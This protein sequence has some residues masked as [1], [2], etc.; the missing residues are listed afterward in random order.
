MKILISYDGSESS[1]AALQDLRLAGLPSICEAVVMTVC[2]S[3]L[4]PPAAAEI[5]EPG[6]EPPHPS[7]REDAATIAA[8]GCKQLQVIFPGWSVRSVSQTGSAPSQVLEYADAW[9]PHLIVVGSHG[10]TRVEQLLLGSVSQRI[11]TEARSSVRVARGRLGE[12]ARPVRLVV[13]FD[14]SEGSWEAVEAVAARTWPKGSDV[15]LVTSLYGA[16]PPEAERVTALNHLETA[17]MTAAA[18]LES[19]GLECVR[20]MGETDPKRLIREHALIAN[21]DC[22]F[23]GSRGFGRLKRLLLGSVAAAVA[24]R[25]HCSVEVV[26]RV[27]H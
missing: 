18:R 7:N 8:R 10:L 2:E 3:W 6:G 21:A 9:E 13:A 17:Q 23:I 22:V 5:L 11:L 24:S 4:P 1:D 15:R 25:A 27:A 19:A 20:V 16:V 12:I 14:D 26:R